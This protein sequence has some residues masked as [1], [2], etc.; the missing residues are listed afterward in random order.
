MD[1]FKN[2][3]KDIIEYIINPYLF[4]CPIYNIVVDWI[5]VWRN[6]YELTVWTV[7]NEIFE[8]LNDLLSINSKNSLLLTPDE[9][10]EITMNHINNQ[11]FC[12]FVINNLNK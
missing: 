8:D 9:A 3:P 11:D 6:E 7:E 5:K 2:L 1:I 10:T 12:N 4:G